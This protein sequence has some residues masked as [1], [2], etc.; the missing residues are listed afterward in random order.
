[1]NLKRASV[2]S[3]LTALST[4]SLALASDDEYSRK[5]LVGLQGVQVLVESLDPQVE[6]AG[7]TKAAIQTDVELKLRLAGIRVLTREEMLKTPGFPTLYI[8][9]NVLPSGE[10]WGFSESVQL[11]QAVILSRDSSISLLN[12]ATW[13]VQGVGTAGPSTIGRYVRDQIKDRV[14]EF[15]NAYLSA[16]PKK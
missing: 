14:D 1:M 4:L 7:L 6:Q 13:S 11:E 12:T 3:V 2:A 9:A 10:R 5:S 16:N 15:I 8:N